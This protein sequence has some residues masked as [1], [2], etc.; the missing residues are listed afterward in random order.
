MCNMRSMTTLTAYLEAANITQSD[1][2]RTVGIDRSVMSRIVNGTVTPS[3]RVAV[4]IERAT[5]G[6]VPASSWVAQPVTEP[7]E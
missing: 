3:L 4:A 7:G 1:I 2:A 5:G 6:A